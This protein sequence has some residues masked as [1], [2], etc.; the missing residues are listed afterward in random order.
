MI[1]TFA[2]PAGLLPRLGMRL[3]PGDHG[4]LLPWHSRRDL[5][6][7]VPTPAL[8]PWW[9]LVVRERGHL[10]ALRQAEHALSVAERMAADAPTPA[11]RQGWEGSAAVLR[12]DCLSIVAEAV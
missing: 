9:R 7:R 11:Q 12:G 8:E 10:E 1:V 4:P 6:P 5:P 2:S 3:A